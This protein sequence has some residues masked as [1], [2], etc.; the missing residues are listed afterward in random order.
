MAHFGYQHDEAE[1]TEY[2]AGGPFDTRF[3]HWRCVSTSRHARSSSKVIAP[4][5]Q[6]MKEM[7]ICSAVTDGSE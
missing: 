1:D 7:M 5:Q 2:T 3:G 4:R 6:T